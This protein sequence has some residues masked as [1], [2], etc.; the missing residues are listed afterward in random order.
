MKFKVGDVVSLKSGGAKMTVEAVSP[1]L[2]SCAWNDGKR[3]YREQYAPETLADAFT[4]EEF[5]AKL[6]EHEAT[7]KSNQDTTAS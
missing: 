2:I 5:L 3:A 6:A 4:V 1:D 7:K